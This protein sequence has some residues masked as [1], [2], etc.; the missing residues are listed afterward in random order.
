MNRYGREVPFGNG[1]VSKIGAFRNHSS[2]ESGIFNL[3]RGGVIDRQKAYPPGLHER[4]NRRIPN[5]ADAK[6]RVRLSLEKCLPS[7]LI[8]VADECEIGG[9]KA[10]VLGYVEKRLKLSAALRQRNAVPLQFDETSNWRVL[11]HQQ[12]ERVVI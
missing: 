7:R 8:A 4:L 12:L 9:A 1:W 6:N 2:I 5:G 3:H 11:R 10:K